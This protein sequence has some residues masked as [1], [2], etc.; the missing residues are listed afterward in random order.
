[1]CK[2]SSSS[3]SDLKE[4]LRPAMALDLHRGGH[5]SC[6]GLWSE[7]A[8]L[9]GHLFRAILKAPRNF[10]RLAVFPRR[11]RA[12]VPLPASQTPLGSS[13]SYSLKAVSKQYS[14]MVVVRGQPSQ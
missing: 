2:Q 1:M 13:V 3:P 4:D 8:Q 6:P 7:M 11:L 14:T 5:R 12:G 9:P 10:L